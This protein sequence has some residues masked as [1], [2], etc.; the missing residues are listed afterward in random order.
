VFARFLAEGYAMVGA[1]ERAIDWLV[2]AVDRGYIN[3]P[4]LAR[5]D[6]CLQ[7]VRSQPRFRRL[8]ETVRERW[9]SFEA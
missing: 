7:R 6:P 4:F 1:A 8:M 2:V 5:H 3:Y 9:Q